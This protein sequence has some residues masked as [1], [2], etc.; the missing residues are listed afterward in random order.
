[1]WPEKRSSNVNPDKQLSFYEAGRLWGEEGQSIEVDGDLSQFLVT[2]NMLCFTGSFTTEDML[3][4]ISRWADTPGCRVLS[5]SN[6]QVIHARLYHKRKTA[7]MV[8]SDSWGGYPDVEFMKVMRATYEHMGVGVAPTPSSLGRATMRYIYDVQ[9]LDRHTALPISCENYIDLHGF[10]GIAVTPKDHIRIDEVTQLDMSSAYLS[11]YDL[12]PD[13]TPEWFHG[14]PGHYWTWFAK[15]SI[16][17]AHDIP[18]GVFPVR[19]KDKRVK[20]PTRKGMYITYVW[21][22][23]AESAMWQGCAVEVHEGWGWP[24]YTTDNQHWA[25]WAYMKRYTSPSEDVESK[26]KRIV[27]SSIGSN[28][29]DR[30]GFVVVGPSRYNPETDFPVPSPYGPLDLWVHPDRDNRSALMPHWNDYTVERT[31]RIVRDFAYPF[32]EEGSL[33]LIDYDSVFTTSPRGRNHIQK[34]SL[35]SIMCKPG[36]WLWQ[37]HHNFRVLRHRMWISDE[38]PSRYGSLLHLVT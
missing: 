22:E 36:T 33:V 35:E 9:L 12:H 7:W 28:G 17:I 23:T 10:G 18:L 27:V 30:S 29:R 14:S 34:Y 21:K 13:G 16:T 4:H 32:A 20:Y 38:E 24:G 37:A 31:N 6:G 2:N 1:M 15:V 26:V 3:R 8:H 25:E 11:T 5:A 19:G